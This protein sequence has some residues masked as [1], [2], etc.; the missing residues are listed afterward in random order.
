MFTPNTDK[1][2]GILLPHAI[3]FYI[4]QVLVRIINS[5][6]FTKSESKVERMSI[7]ETIS[8]ENDVFRAYAFWTAITIIKM[9]IMSPLTGHY[10]FKKKV[11]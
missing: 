3:I 2:T 4:Q 7:I 6:I 5:V 8:L 9:L 1:I 10:R 11:N